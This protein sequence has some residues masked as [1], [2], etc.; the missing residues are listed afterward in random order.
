MTKPSDDMRH[1]WNSIL[2]KQGLDAI[3]PRKP[4][5]KEKREQKKSGK[6]LSRGALAAAG[7][8]AGSRETARLRKGRTR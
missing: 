2:W 5:R 8:L 4:S 6:R 7:A 1:K 3:Q